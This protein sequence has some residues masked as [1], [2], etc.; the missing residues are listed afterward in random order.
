MLKQSLIEGNISLR[1]N[2]I[3]ID[4]DLEV[5]Q[6]YLPM[7]LKTKIK[8]KAEQDNITMDELMLELVQKE[9]GQ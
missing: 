7:S 5:L 8:K 2:G 6:L 3:L 9:F 1:H 4:S